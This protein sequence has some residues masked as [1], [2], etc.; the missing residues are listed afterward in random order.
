MKLVSMVDYVL[1]L[2]EL[3]MQTYIFMSERHQRIFNYAKFL[4]QPLKLEMFVPCNDDGEPLEKP[5][6]YDWYFN[7][8]KAKELVKNEQ[9]I[10]QYKRA[11]EKVFFL[12]FDAVKFRDNRLQALKY[13]L[14]TSQLDSI[15]VDEVGF[16]YYNSSMDIERINTVEDLIKYNSIQ[17]T[18]NAIKQLK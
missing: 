5:K 17:L 16:Y 3:T 10:L 13:N 18:E 7:E 2:Q 1:Q 12:G 4:K 11:K 15:L 9:E 8:C 6:N 14:S